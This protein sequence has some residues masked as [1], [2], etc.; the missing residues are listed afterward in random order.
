MK[1]AFTLLFALCLTA[2][3]AMAQSNDSLERAKQQEA[4]LKKQQQEQA[5]L[6][7]EQQKAAEKAQK[8]QVEAEKKAMKDAAAKQKRE[9]A[10]AANE[11]RAEQKKQQKKQQRAEDLAAWGRKNHFSIDPFVG[12]A[13]SQRGL[14]K[15]SPYN[16]WGADFGLDLNYHYPIA[17]RWDLNV[18]LGFRYAL[19]AY[20]HAVRFDA[21][22]ISVLN[23]GNYNGTVPTASVST[24]EVPIKLSHVSKDN[25]NEIFLGLVPAFNIATTTTYELVDASGQLQ[26]VSDKNLK[27]MNRFRCDLVLGRQGKWMVFAPGVQAYVNLMPT[28]VENASG[29]ASPIHEFGIRLAL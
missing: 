5:D 26:S 10:K 21:N 1:K 15:D 29:L 14:T 11:A 3:A 27:L 23:K 25:Q 2:G 4:L 24:A 8:E 9:K 19:Y 12:L 16:S 13:Y 18:G 6:L 22:G 17:K 20:N 28:Y 7:K